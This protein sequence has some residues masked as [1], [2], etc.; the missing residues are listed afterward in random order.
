ML[1]DDTGKPSEF[2]QADMRDLVTD[3][4]APPSTRDPDLLPFHERSWQDFEKIVLVV[5]EH[6]D[7]L[8][9]VRVYGV[10]GQRQYGIDIYGSGDDGENV[11][12][13]AKRRVAFGVTE[14]KAAVEEFANG[15]RPVNATTLVICVSCDT[16]RTEMSETLEQLREKHDFG[17]ELYDRRRLSEKLR[18]RP[19]LV[20]RLFG[21]EWATA[22]CD[23]VDWPVPERTSA[24]VLADALVRG[25]IT[26]LGLEA[27]F[28][29]CNALAA[30]DPVTAAAGLASSSKR[31]A[32]RASPISP[33]GFDSNMPSFLSGL[34]T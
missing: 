21:P 16:D 5:A 9:G 34:A 15:F 12:Y 23:R 20:R 19:E 18:T 22:F 2:D 27:D 32:R 28:N 24:D 8:R 31:L 10:P 30:T 33:S 29:H 26:A 14:L 4:V 13:Q 11:G 25:P 3:Q 6:V 1:G 17:I 7:G